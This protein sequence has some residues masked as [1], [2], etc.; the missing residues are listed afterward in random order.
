MRAVW[1]LL[2]VY[3]QQYN[4]IVKSET[5]S[6]TDY[7]YWILSGRLETDKI[8]VVIDQFIMWK[9]KEYHSTFTYDGVPNPTSKANARLVVSEDVP[10]TDL[11]LRGVVNASDTMGAATGSGGSSSGN[12]TK[13]SGAE[14]LVSGSNGGNLISGLALA[15]LSFLM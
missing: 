15:L 8:H 3:R 14:A 4:H 5:L 6:S 7:N 10:T 12:G 11:A 2:T 1:V 9:G 13:G